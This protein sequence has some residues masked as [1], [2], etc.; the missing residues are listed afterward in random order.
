MGATDPTRMEESARQLAT[1]LHGD[2]ADAVIL[3]PV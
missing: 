3:V 2:A 1:V